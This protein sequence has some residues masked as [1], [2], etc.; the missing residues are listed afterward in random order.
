MRRGRYDSLEFEIGKQDLC[1]MLKEAEQD[2]WSVLRGHQKDSF[3]KMLELL[4]NAEQDQEL[5]LINM[6]LENPV[7]RSGYKPIT[8]STT[9]GRVTISR[10]RLRKQ[11]YERTKKR[12]LISYGIYI[13]SVYLQGKWSL[14]YEISSVDTA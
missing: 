5:E 9:I 11:L 3:K 14:P 13:L 10:P 4:L 1:F 8:I 7:H 6:P 2:V 12:Y